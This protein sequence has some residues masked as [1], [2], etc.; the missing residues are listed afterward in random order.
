VIFAEKLE[1]IRA[2]VESRPF[3]GPFL[4][5]VNRRHL[6]QYYERI[7]H[8]IDLSTIKDKISRYDYRTADAL[9]KDFELMKNNAAKF[10]GEVSVITKEA[11]AIYDWVRDQVQGTMD[12]LGKLEQAVQEQ[13]SGGSTKVK[14]SKKSSIA[15][16]P[17]KKDG[18]MSGGSASGNTSGAV[19]VVGG[20][21]VNL[22]NFQFDDGSDDTDSDG[23]FE[24]DM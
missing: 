15:G 18:G 5:P 23:S 19:G 20:V 13:W 1:A 7:T 10:N 22:G 3:A 17:S 24:L 6:P 4:K 14:K 16:G 9:V 8:P 2:A 21:Q 11:V 12:E